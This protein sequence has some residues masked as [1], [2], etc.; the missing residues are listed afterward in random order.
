MTFEG[1]DKCMK[2]L[3]LGWQ[4]PHDTVHLFTEPRRLEGHEARAKGRWFRV[5]VDGK[6]KVG[7]NND[8]E[9]SEMERDERKLRRT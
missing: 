9:G 4:L 2:W 8:K 7:E 1:N 3:G 6:R 5:R